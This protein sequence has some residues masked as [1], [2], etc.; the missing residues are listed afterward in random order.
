[1]EKIN[2]PE[3][4]K[5]DFKNALDAAVKLQTFNAKSLASEIGI[6]ALNASIFIGFMDKYRFIYPSGKNAEKTVCISEEE[7]NAIERDIDAFV[8]PEVPEKEEVPE[9]F[10]TS[11]PAFFGASGKSVEVKTDKIVI[12]DEIIEF[13]I[14]KDSVILPEFKKATFFKKGYIDFKV[15]NSF[16]KIYF[17][18]GANNTA[19]ALFESIKNDLDKKI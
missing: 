10:L 15:S 14:D 18:R 17:K 3:K 4:Y 9:F 19:E 7:W 13:S 8:P 2:V 12:C 5:E 16:T 1:M 6:S 11:F